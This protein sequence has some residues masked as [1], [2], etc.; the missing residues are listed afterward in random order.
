M[1]PKVHINLGALVENWRMLARRAAPAEA[2]A[3]VKAD[4]Y[5]LGAARCAA[6]LL[7]AGC[8][9]FYVAWPHEGAALREALGPGPEIAV[10]HGPTADTLALFQRHALQPVLNSLEQIRLW[11]DSGATIPFAIHLDTGMNRLGIHAR[12][13]AAAGEALGP[14]RP[15]HLV[16]H[17]ASPDEPENLLNAQQLYLFQS[18][19]PLFPATKKSFSSTGGVYLGH[20]FA[21]DEIRPGIGLY[22]GGPVPASGPAPLPV[23]T[24]TAHILQVREVGRGETTGYGASWT[25]DGPRTLATLG[26]GYADG[27]LRAA[28]NRGYGV[29]RGQKRPI[30]GRVSMDLIMLDVTGLGAAAGDEV[31]LLGPAMPLAEQAAAMNT[32]DYELLT[33]LGP[34]IARFYSGGE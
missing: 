14:L 8:R 9:R 7:K 27:F 30:L 18:A 23:V 4:A 20:P 3:V 10:F 26:I 16:S 1:T 11:R 28:S 33:R 31:E 6:A 25:S 34:R 17:L 13:W 24:L 32:I 12:D 21:F 19:I 5:G 15:D 22:G 2:A 29:C